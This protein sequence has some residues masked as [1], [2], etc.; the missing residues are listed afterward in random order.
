MY[1]LIM[2]GGHGTR[3]WPLSREMMPKQMLK[4]VGSNTMIQD[5][6]QRILPLVPLNHLYIATN[7]KHAENIDTQLKEISKIKSNINFIV[8][9]MGKNTAPAI[10]VAATYINEI[11][12]ESIMVV[13]PADHVIQ[14]KTEFLELLKQA[15]RLAAQ[16]YLV[17]FGIKPTRPETGYGYIK[18]GKKTFAGFNV[19]KFT[20]KPNLKTAQK[21]LKNPKYFWNGGIFV[22]QTK[23]ILQEI[24]KYLPSLYE[25][26]DF[27]RSAPNQEEALKNF[28][29]EI[30]PISIDYGIMEHTNKA[31]VIPADISWNDIGSWAA[32]DEV[33]EK[34][35]NGN[36]IAGNVVDINSQNSIIYGGKELVATIGLNNMVV[37]STDDAILICPKNKSQEVK[38]VVDKIKEKGSEEYLI[39]KTISR[40]WGYYTVL[41]KGNNYTIRRISIMPKAKIK[42][43]LH[44]HRSE[45]WIV[46]SGVAK[47]TKGNKVYYV[48][49]NEST[50][51]PRSTK[52]RIENTGAIPL[53][54]IEVQN[55]E[56]LEEDLIR[57][58][59]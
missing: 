54:I 27:L 57:F 3:F 52:H 50:Y 46:I 7:E 49:P 19:D 9:P 41:E 48:H 20:E 22:W 30:K 59:D 18:A 25:K 23:T 36:I 42:L 1:A 33:V 2:A 12:P 39:H 56:Y 58:E 45:H 14:K 28:Y 53:Q 16:G 6:V 13:L 15:E 47:I 10:A 29:S 31:V 24:K 5:T 40:P 11:D 44:H 4:I 43:Q 35:L 55:G 51:I 37:V 34:D 8:E 21:Y 32:I 38:N 17:T 26:L